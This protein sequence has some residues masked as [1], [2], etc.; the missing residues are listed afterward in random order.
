MLESAFQNMPCPVAECDGQITFNTH[1]LLQGK[2]FSCPKCK[3]TIALSQQ[4]NENVQDAL[5]EFEAL[6]EG[7]LKDNE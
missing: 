3:T 7:T 2:E 6:R 1:Q 5:E 4:S